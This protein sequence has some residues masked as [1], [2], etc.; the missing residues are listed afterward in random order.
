MRSYIISM[1]RYLAR[2]ILR[3]YKPVVVAVAGS[4][5]KTAAKEAIFAVLRAKFSVRTT[6]KDYHEEL[7][8]LGTLVGIQEGISPKAFFSLVGMLVRSVAY[9]LFP[10]RYPAVLVIEMGAKRPRDILYLTKIVPPSMGVVTAVAP[11]YMEFFRN[12]KRVALEKRRLVEALPPSGTAILNMDDDFVQEFTEYAEGKVVGYGIRSQ[13]AQVSAIE[14]RE[15]LAHDNLEE[16]GGISFKI[17]CDGSVVPMRLRNVLSSSHIYAALAAVTVGRA[18]EMNMVEISNALLRYAPPPGRMRLIAGV[19]GT[20]II[21]DTFNSSPQAVKSAL[22]TL[23]HLELKPSATRY[24]ILG[25]MI[26]LGDLNELEHRAVGQIAA[27]EVDVLIG[28]G[29]SAQWMIDEARKGGMSEDR[30]FHFHTREEGLEHFLQERIRP[31]DVLLI[32]GAR[33]MK[34]E[35]LVKGLMAEPL[36]AKQLL[37]RQD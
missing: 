10:L 19:K 18:F 32:K 5:G 11:V 25:D 20:T 4:V 17:L 8:I 26:E 13:Q 2:L 36:K 3:K 28:V 33:T 1:L 35:Q 16:C 34:M 12:L 22:E 9:I 7:D 15:Y 27:Q 29:I 21:D 14:V 23:G 31:G 24:A 30:V 6:P 37:C